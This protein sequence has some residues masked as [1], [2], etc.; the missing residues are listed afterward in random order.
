MLRKL[1]NF[2]FSFSWIKK[3]KIDKL[4]SGDCAI[5]HIVINNNY[6]IMFEK[7]TFQL[8]ICLS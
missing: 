8:L 4:E 3:K 6:Q 2:N 5:P 1:S 7:I